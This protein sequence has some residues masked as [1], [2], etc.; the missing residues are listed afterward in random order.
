MNPFLVLAV[1]KGRPAFSLVLALLWLTVFPRL[2]KKVKMMEVY[3]YVFKTMEGYKFKTKVYTFDKD[4]K[5]RN[6]RQLEEWEREAFGVKFEVKVDHSLA[7]KLAW[8]SR[9]AKQRA[10]R[11]ALCNACYAIIADNDPDQ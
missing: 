1:A 8:T 4:D 3:K 7:D 5:L 10:Y 2:V 6:K 11:F 9:E